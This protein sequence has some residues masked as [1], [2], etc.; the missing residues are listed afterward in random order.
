MFYTYKN[1]E[2]NDGIE[3]LRALSNQPGLQCYPFVEI[4]LNICLFHL[5]VAPV[6]DESRWQRFIF[7]RVD[8]V[9]SFAASENIREFRIHIQTRRKQEK[10]YQLKRVAKIARG[11]T[12]RGEIAYLFLCADG[13]VEIVSLND[14]SQVDIKKTSTL[15]VEPDIK[16]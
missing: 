9:F 14:V 11:D 4:P 10:D 5:D 6:D 12:R 8:N 16:I 2:H 13:S 7:D 3:V 1:S 15:W